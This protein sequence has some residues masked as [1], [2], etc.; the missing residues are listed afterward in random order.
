MPSGAN[1]L[2]ETI[3][4]ENKNLDFGI[5]SRVL[6]VCIGCSGKT[7]GMAVRPERG[8]SSPGEGRARTLQKRN[9]G[10]KVLMF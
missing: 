9:K 4:Q 3:K 6:Y 7:P 8:R 1:Y 5:L 2:V 10:V